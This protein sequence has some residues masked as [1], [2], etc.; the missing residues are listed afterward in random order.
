MGREQLQ[1][2]PNVEHEAIAVEDAIRHDTGFTLT[3]AGG[4]QVGARKLV[5][6]TGV[7]DELPAIPGFQ[8]L[9]GKSIAHCPYCHGWEVRDK[10]LA[11]YGN[12][13]EGFELVRLLKG[14]SDDLV[15]CTNGPATLTESQRARLEANRVAI[16]E[17]FI[18][19]LEGNHGQ[20][21]AIVFADGSRL[22]RHTIFIR[23][24]QQQRSPLPQQLGCSFTANGLVQVDFVGKTEI[25]GL[26]V[27]GDAAQRAQSISVA[28]ASGTLAASML[29]HEILAE[30]FG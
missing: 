18:A 28:V 29:N 17:E 16:R 10:P 14:W 25:P 12:G 22:E 7:R 15:L 13:D 23:P 6:A 4:R 9:W 26:F 19:G 5:L 27:V 30:D 3:L 20:L 2:Y 24:R 8:E 11:I 1:P 21:E